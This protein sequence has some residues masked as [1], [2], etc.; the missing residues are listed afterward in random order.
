[1]LALLLAFVYISSFV[2]RQKKMYR[3]RKSYKRLKTLK[4]LPYIVAVDHKEK[5]F[6]ISKK[7]FSLVRGSSYNSINE[8]K[9]NG[10]WLLLLTGEH[11]S[12]LHGEDLRLRYY[13][14]K[15]IRRVKQLPN[16]MFIALGLSKR[17]GRFV[18]GVLD[19][20][21]KTVISLRYRSISLTNNIFKC[22]DFKGNKTNFTRMG[23]KISSPSKKVSINEH[24]VFDYG[25]YQKVT[26]VEDE[27]YLFK[28]E[29]PFL[30]NAYKVI[31]RNHKI[32]YLLNQN[33][34]AALFNG[35]RFYY[36]RENWFVQEYVSVCRRIILSNSETK[37][38]MMLDYDFDFIIRT[39]YPIKVLLGAEAYSVRFQIEDPGGPIPINPSGVKLLTW[40]KVLVTRLRRYQSVLNRTQNT[41]AQ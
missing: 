32:F 13:S 5:S 9:V 41:G 27:T 1:M 26:V 34:E 36:L 37:E 20:D 22:C 24:E 30:H 3:L 15:K 4:N 18:K 28:S 7:D 25:D 39:Q 21:F 40:D 6:L 38:A 23:E 17:K 19:K 2:D 11:S 35:K 14:S 16:K 10:E 33:N 29:K 8:T 12:S 31:K